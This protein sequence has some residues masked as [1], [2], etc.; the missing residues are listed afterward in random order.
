MMIDTDIPPL[1]RPSVLY[2]P[3]LDVVE[4]MEGGGDVYLPG[5]FIYR[6][7]YG[8]CVAYGLSPRTA[9]DK[10]DWLWMNR[11]DVGPKRLGYDRLVVQCKNPGG[12]V[13]SP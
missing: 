1:M 2:R 7:S 13:V 4:V 12:R 8:D 5:S 3:E 6:A 9:M 11:A 10:F